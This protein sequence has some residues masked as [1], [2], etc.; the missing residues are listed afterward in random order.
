MYIVDAYNIMSPLAWDGNFSTDS[1]DK[2]LAKARSLSK[3]W[4]VVDV[5]LVSP[6]NNDSEIVAAWLGGSRTI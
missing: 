6:L 4:E 1:R 5:R 2:A 3:E